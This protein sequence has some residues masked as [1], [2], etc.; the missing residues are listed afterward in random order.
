METVAIRGRGSLDPGFD[1]KVVGR[2]LAPMDTT[3]LHAQF[4][5]AE[6]QLRRAIISVDTAKS[7]VAQREAER[8]SA[9]AVAFL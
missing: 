3:Q 1:S 5:Q 4:R 2:V 8:K 7:L 9:T 6:A